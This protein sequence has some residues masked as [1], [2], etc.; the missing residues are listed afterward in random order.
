MAPYYDELMKVVPYRMWVGYYLLLLAQQDAH[1]VKILDVCCGTGTM[2]EMLSREGFLL[3]G[4]D[5]SP[6][7][8]DQAR[9][10][11]RLKGQ[12]IRYE[13]MDA[14][15]F[16]MHDTYD[17]AFSFFDSLN[18][19][20][21]PERLQSAFH[22]VYKHLEP[23]GSFIFDVNTAYAF[24]TEL[25]NQQNLKGKGAIKYRWVGDWNPK[26]RIITVN[27]RFWKDDKEFTEVHQQRAYSDAE[28]R[29]MLQNAGFEQVKSYHSYTLEHPRDKSDRVHYT[30][31]KPDPDA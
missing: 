21:D 20:L 5:L 24:E 19:I 14:A 2:C 17:A 30:C 6:Q 16:E 11:A 23:G 18:N 7:M 28:L 9:E 25:F 22:H 29:E 1:P 4:F 31:L 8:I 15:E 26:T 13:V 10:K 3:A 12:E 27:M